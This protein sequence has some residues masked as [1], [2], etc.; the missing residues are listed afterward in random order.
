[1]V[2][3]GR[4]LRQACQVSRRNPAS[5]CEMTVASVGESRSEDEV[6]VV[7]RPE[8]G[9]HRVREDP[10][11]PEPLLGGE[12]GHHL[13]VGRQVDLRD[14]LEHQRRLRDRRHIAG[15]GRARVGADPD[16]LVLDRRRHLGDV[17]STV[18]PDRG[19][20]GV[21]GQLRREL[22]PFHVS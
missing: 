18:G 22:V 6:V 5:P 2:A 20:V 8:E 16:R 3:P 1:M 17:R 14:R 13:D 9:V 12:V 7:G 15:L 10:A 19:D 21:S 4:A 11:V